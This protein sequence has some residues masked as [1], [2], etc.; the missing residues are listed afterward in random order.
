M[1]SRKTAKPTSPGVEGPRLATKLVQGGLLR[2]NFSETSEALFMTS[3]YVYASAE[4]AE[5]AFAN[6]NPHFIYSRYSN[7]TV[8][9]FEQRMALLEGTEASRATASGMAA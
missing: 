7:P 5:A 4:E 1:A 8:Q 6:K 9:M 2:S 3:G